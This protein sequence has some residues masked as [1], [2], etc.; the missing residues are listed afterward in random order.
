MSFQTRKTFIH[1]HILMKSEWV[2]RHQ[3]FLFFA[4]KKYSC[5]FIKL[6]LNLWC[7]MDY[8]NDVLAKFLRLERCSC[9]C[10]CR[11]REPSNFIKNLNL[12][13]EDVLQRS[14]SF[15]MTLGWVFKTAFNFWVNYPFNRLFPEYYRYFPHNFHCK[16]IN[17]K[18]F[19][20]MIN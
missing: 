10:L 3:L 5:S 2:S 18:T 9:C 15:G 14:Y 13:S 19:P 17:V 16:S 11:F 7:H 1:L 20:V 8:F 12:C 4:Q 6:W